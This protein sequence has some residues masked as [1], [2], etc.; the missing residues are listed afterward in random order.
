ME[1]HPALVLVGGAVMF[2]VGFLMHAIWGRRR[3][4]R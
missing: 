3:N 2:I 1:C 4:G